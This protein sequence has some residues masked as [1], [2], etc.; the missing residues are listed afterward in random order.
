MFT[1]KAAKTKTSE[2]DSHGY[3]FSFY[4]R[5]FM[6]SREGKSTTYRNGGEGG[7]E[8]PIGESEVRGR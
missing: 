6:N 3:E 2:T 1:P 5:S 7:I 8:T 4:A